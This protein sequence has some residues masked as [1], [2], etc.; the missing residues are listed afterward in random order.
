MGVAPARFIKGVAKAHAIT[1]FD[2]VSAAF[3]DT[4]S[5]VFPAFS[6]AEHFCL[7]APN[8]RAELRIGLEV[9]LERLPGIRLLEQPTFLGAALGLAPGDS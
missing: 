9:L 3:L 5:V 8:A 7:G 6:V 1:R 4:R 2:D